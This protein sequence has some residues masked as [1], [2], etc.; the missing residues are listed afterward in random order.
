M[1]DAECKIGELT[2]ENE[3]WKKWPNE[4]VSDAA[5]SGRDECPL[6]TVCPGDRGTAIDDLFTAAAATELARSMTWD[7]HNAP[8]PGARVGGA[9]PL[10]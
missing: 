2:L 1:R 7:S 8:V 5:R 9:T 6:A 10:R 3:I 4:E